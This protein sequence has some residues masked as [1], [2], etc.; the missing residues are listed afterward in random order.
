MHKVR[1]AAPS[2][3]VPW[4]RQLNCCLHLLEDRK[5][6]YWMEQI[7]VY[8]CRSL[9]QSE[10]HGFMTVAADL[11][12]FFIMSYLTFKCA[13]ALSPSHLM[14]LY[15]SVFFF[16]FPIVLQIK[17]KFSMV[18]IFHYCPNQTNYHLLLQ[19]QLTILVPVRKFCSFLLFSLRSSIWKS[20]VTTYELCRCFL[21]NCHILWL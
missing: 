10:V 7:M 3:A 19:S 13:K 6:N 21:A 5:P 16:G 17:H 14:S 1:N 11:E 9:L 8:G 4:P 12:A 2:L 20:T 15:Y 18:F